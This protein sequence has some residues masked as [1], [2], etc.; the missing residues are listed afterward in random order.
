MKDEQFDKEI[1]DL[2]QQRKSEIVAPS[3]DLSKPLV[4]KKRSIFSFFSI[5]T[6]GAAASFGIMAIV[7]HF[8]KSP[9]EVEQSTI[10][11]YQVNITEKKSK[12]LEETTPLTTPELPPKPEV[13]PLNSKLSLLE[14]MK[15][16]TQLNDVE[17]FDLSLVQVVTLPHLIEPKVAIKPI[18]K[19]MPK[20]TQKALQE[21][22][23]GAIRFRYEVDQ[24]GDVKNIHIVKSE[25]GREL[26]RSA[27]KALGKWKYAPD[28]VYAE[29][30]EVVFEF[31]VEK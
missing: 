6:V 29:N 13:P 7:T 5:L 31:S 20:F 30:Y 12:K 21:N 3:I 15:N 27:K 2:Y 14:P 4:E 10:A 9:Q 16:S 8:A 26:E 28:I 11:L 19:V 25:V 22:Q 18:Y 23:L 24:S 1:A 17:N